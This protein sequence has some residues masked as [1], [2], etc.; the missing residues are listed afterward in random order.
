[1]AKGG[2]AEAAPAAAP[3]VGGPAAAVDPQLVAL[4]LRQ[5]PRIILGTGSSS[6]RG[7]MDELAA[8]YGFS[9][10]VA[11][12][13]IDEKAIRHE[14]ARHLVLRLAHAKAAA[15]AAKLAAA[16]GA[17]PSG[18]L[19]TCDQVVLHEGQILEKPEDEAQARQYIAG[20]A[21]APASTVGSVVLT[22]LTTGRSWEGVDVAEIHFDPIS[23]ESVDK[24]VAEGEVFWCAGGLMVEHS[25]VQPHV[26]RMDGALDSVMGLDKRL[27]LRLLCAVAADASG[28]RGDGGGGDG[29]DRSRGEGP[30]S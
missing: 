8:E 9:Y 22:D 26:T 12:A 17:P 2:S 15:I 21:R 7:I 16:E 5:H 18:L 23:Q 13:D 30:S 20:Y 14:D 4:A 24:L 25:L 28:G 29:D 6:R 3:P 1:M 10:E 11:K 19:I 27:L